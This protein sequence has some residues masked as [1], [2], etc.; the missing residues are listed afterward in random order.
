MRRPK[1]RT[2]LLVLSGFL[3]PVTFYYLSPV[4]ILAGV[5]EGIVTG[6][7][8]VFGVLFLSA[9][10][11]GR[12]FCGWVCPG[13]AIAGAAGV[14]RDRPLTRGWVRWV[15]FGIWAPWLGGIA[16]LAIQAGG[17]RR[18]EL[19]YQTWYGISVA[20]GEGLIAFSAVV[21]GIAGLTLLVGRRGFCHTLCWMAPFMVLGRSLANLAR[22]PGLRLRARREKCVAC[23]ACTRVCPMSLDVQR[24]VEGGNLEQRDCILCA[25]CADIC[26]KNVIGLRI[27]PPP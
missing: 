26:P 12:A 16:F 24:M 2:A 7:F 18:V 3:F 22:L 11:F 27:A 20:T 23:G 21:L 14:L 6:S 5:S 15:K 1:V 8:V 10:A 17:L 9:L 13:G 4:V 25:R 19:A